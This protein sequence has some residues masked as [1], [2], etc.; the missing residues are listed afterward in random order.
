M[1]PV[2]IADTLQVACSGSHLGVRWT[3]VYGLHTTYAGPLTQTDA[4]NIGAEFETFYDSIKASLSNDWTMDEVVIYDLRGPTDPSWEADITTV[5]GTN[6]GDNLSP[7]IAGCVTHR[8]AKRG[9]RYQGRTFLCGWTENDNTADGQW[10][11]ATRT[12]VQNAFAIL[13]NSLVLVPTVEPE[14]AVI[15]KIG[16]FSTPITVSTADAEWDHQ[17]RRKRLS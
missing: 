10:L 16:G 13:R 8:T 2:V 9:R 12:A 15:S 11:A 6:N 3:N 5:T 4:D 7:A 17:D 14:F 1:P